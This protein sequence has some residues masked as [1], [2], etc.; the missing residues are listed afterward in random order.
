[1]RGPLVAQVAL[2]LHMAGRAEEGKAFADT[3]LRTVLPPAQEAEIRLQIAKMLWIPAEDRVDAGRRALA[4][5][6]VPLDLRANHL[7]NLVSS[8][9]G[10]GRFAEAKASG[11]RPSRPRRLPAIRRSPRSPTCAWR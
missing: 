4:L 9:Q 5:D 6:G 3:A 10:A 1:M 2:S 7:A 8:S 11:P